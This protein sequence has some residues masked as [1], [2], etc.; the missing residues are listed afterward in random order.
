MKVDIPDDPPVSVRHREGWCATRKKTTS[1]ADHIKTVCGRTVIYPFDIAEEWPD[2]PDCKRLLGIR[3]ENE[4][5]GRKERK[6]KW[7]EH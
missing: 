6:I 7:Q 2:C 3:D 5:P 1:Y 4:R